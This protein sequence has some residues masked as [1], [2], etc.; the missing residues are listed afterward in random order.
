M[1]VFSRIFIIL[2]ILGFAGIA[3]ASLKTDEIA[4]LQKQ[5]KDQPVGKRIAFWAERFIGTPYDKDPLGAY[6]SCR[7]IVCDSEVD[8]MYLVFRA[9]E[10]GTSNTPDEAKERALDLRFKTRGRV[11]GGL[12]MNY[13]DRF[14]YGEDMVYSGKWG[15]DITSSLGNT[16]QIPGSRGHETVTYLPKEELSKKEDYGRLRDGDIIFFIK[17]PAKRVVGEIVGHLG[18][19]KV[20]GGVPMLIHASGTKKAN[21]RPGGGVVKKV[22]LPGYLKDTGFIGVMVTRF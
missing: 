19:V 4:A 16:K 1:R 8:C 18:I 5:L 10:L 14:Q 11:E 13:D 7:K 6:V 9:V 20:E 12:V 15:K 21:G 3:T 22:S 17:D 2:T